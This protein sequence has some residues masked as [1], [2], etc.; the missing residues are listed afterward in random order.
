M[1][2]IDDKYGFIG[3]DGNVVIKAKYDNASR[4]SNGLAVVRINLGFEGFINCNEEFII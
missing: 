4:F 3:V 1:Y 2:E